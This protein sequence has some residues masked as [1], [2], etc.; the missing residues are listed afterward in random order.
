MHCRR[1]WPFVVLIQKRYPS[2]IDDEC[3]F[4]FNVIQKVATT[5]KSATDWRRDYWRFV[6]V[7][8]TTNKNWNVVD[9]RVV[10]FVHCIRV[11]AEW[12]RAWFSSCRPLLRRMS[13][14]YWYLL[15]VNEN[16]LWK[17]EYTWFRFNHWDI[18]TIGAIICVNCPG[19]GNIVWCSYLDIQAPSARGRRIE[20][21]CGPFQN[22]I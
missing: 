20:A 12:H 21:H 1:N 8:M 2:Y 5:I 16:T 13:W 15:W 18:H 19:V 10:P 3:A 14:K 4:A 6:R 17:V 9:L 11:I 7:A 22:Y